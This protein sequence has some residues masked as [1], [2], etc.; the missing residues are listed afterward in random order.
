MHVISRK[1]FNDAT[2]KYPND[3]TAIEAVYKSLRNG[4][5]R[6]PNELRSLF[7][8]LDNFKYKDKWW[9]VDIG[10]NNLRLIA[11]IEFR[12]CRMYV[13]HIVSHAE[14]DKLCKKYAKEAG[15]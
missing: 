6:S 10:G 5:F 13:K 3:A 12:D 7:P 11:F 8:S 1:P 14:Y 2:H 9:V 15:T 4:D